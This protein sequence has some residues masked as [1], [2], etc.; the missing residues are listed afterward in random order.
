[1]RHHDPGQ[2][3]PLGEDRGNPL[4]ELELEFRMHPG[5][6]DA[7]E[8]LGGDRSH[9]V[10]AG[11]GGAEIAGVERSAG[12]PGDR[13]PG[14]NEVDFRERLSRRLRSK[15]EDEGSGSSTRESDHG[16]GFISGCQKWGRRA[17]R[18]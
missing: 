8:I 7:D 12:A 14:A 3:G 11:Q 9:G 16:T 2:F 10:Q 4:R 15:H 1:M 17:V 5:T 13:A 18:R 6:S